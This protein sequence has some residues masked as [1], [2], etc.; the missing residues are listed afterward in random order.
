MNYKEEI[1]KM[2]DKAEYRV[3]VL[4]YWHLRALLGIK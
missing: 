2:I 3:Q 1:K 4:V